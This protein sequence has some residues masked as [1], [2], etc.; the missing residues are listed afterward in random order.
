MEWCLANRTVVFLSCDGKVGV[1]RNLC[2]GRMAGQHE[3][4]RIRMEA[5]DHGLLDQSAQAG[6]KSNPL[7]LTVPAGG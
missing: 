1:F 4:I 3:V 5:Y 6:A 2:G 7:E